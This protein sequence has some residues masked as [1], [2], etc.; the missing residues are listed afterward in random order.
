MSD[1]FS[2]LFKFVSSFLSYLFE[3][4]L[5]QLSVPHGIYDSACILCTVDTEGGD[6]DT[7]FAE[8]GPDYSEPGKHV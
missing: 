2:V 7:N 4:Y 3:K 8:L 1:P 6:G 5:D